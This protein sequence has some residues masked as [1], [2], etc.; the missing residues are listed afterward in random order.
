M[1]QKNLESFD[2]SLKQEIAKIRSLPEGKRWEYVWEYYKVPLLMV[3]IGILF[4]WMLGSFAVS[5]F[6]GTFFPKDPISMAVAVP[7]FT[8]CDAW[9]EECLTAIGYEE[10]EENMQIL[11]TMPH[12]PEQDD[13]VISSTLWFTAGQPDIFIV[14]Q[15]GYDYLLTLDVLAE[16]E[17]A[18]PEALQA[19]A[20]DFT[21]DAHALDVSSTAFAR[22]HGLD[23]QPLYLCMY[24]SGHGFTRALDIVAYILTEA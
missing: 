7:G 13:F 19:L 10:K 9:L 8:N 4:V 15:A 21:V 5:A 11:T 24:V 20:E 6:M 23:G 1:K 22:Q 17:T 3:C 18:W 14:D 2:F 16:I 12:T